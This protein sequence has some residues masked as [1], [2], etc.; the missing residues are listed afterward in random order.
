MKK[1]V[2][3]YSAHGSN[4]NYNI[5][6]EILMD[7]NRELTDADES[8]LRQC[9]DVLVKAIHSETASNDSEIKKNAEKE[10]QEILQLFGN[11]VIFVE[12]IPNGYCD[13]YL[14]KYMP[15]FK[16]TTDKGR[17]K[18]GWRKRVINIDWS[19]S[20]I[21][22]T[23]EELFSDEETTK[24]DKHIHAWGYEKA[25]EYINKLLS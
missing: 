22:E 6:I 8:N 12:E 5:S 9:V 23:A 2:F 7:I 21:M 15:W 20:N 4:A 10:R 1:P 24:Y 16:I 25:G 14:C 3:N 18:I 11:K 19:E 13:C 17:I